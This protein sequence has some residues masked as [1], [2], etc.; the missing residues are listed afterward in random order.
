[1]S[2]NETYNLEKYAINPSQQIWKSFGSVNLTKGDI[3]I[4]T[5]DSLPITDNI[6]NAALELLKQLYPDLKGLQGLTFI[7]NDLLEPIESGF[8]F[9]R[10]INEHFDRWI[11]ISNLMAEKPD[12]EVL[13][14]DSNYNPNKKYSNHC[15]HTIFKSMNGRKGIKVIVPL[16]SQQKYRFQSGLYAIAF[17]QTLCCGEDPSQILFA[18]LPNNLRKHLI[19]CFKSD[20]FTK[21]PLGNTCPLFSVVVTR[22]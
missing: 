10:V 14:Y 7:E 19:D 13:I 16:V 9:I 2:R 6:M 5:Y 12:E 3:E 1:M 22:D 8:R 4:L 15:N 20:C 11:A 18:S 17:L 21:F